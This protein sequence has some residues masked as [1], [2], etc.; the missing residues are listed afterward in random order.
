MSEEPSTTDS[1][2][3]SYSDFIK[4][5]FIAPIRTVSVIDDEY[6]TLDKLLLRQQN[7]K[8]NSDQFFA[9]DKRLI[10]SEDLDQL[11]PILRFCRAN[12]RNW[13]LCL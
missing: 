13:M 11:I 8:N 9:D 5:A 3:K 10:A 2:I 4:E 1:G 6:P 12:E 7:Y